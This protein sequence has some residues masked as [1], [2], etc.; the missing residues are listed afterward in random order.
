M[1]KRFKALLQLILLFL[2]QDGALF[3]YIVLAQSLNQRR[4]GQFE[5]LKF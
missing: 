1:V 3:Y 2:N 5:L 4:E